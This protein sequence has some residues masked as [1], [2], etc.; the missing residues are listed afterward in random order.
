[1]KHAI[2]LALVAVSACVAL[3]PVTFTSAE[4]AAI[5]AS[6]GRLPASPPPDPS[7]RWAD[8]PAAADV[9]RDLFFDGR[10]SPA[11]VSCATCHD[12][13]T[14]FQD[15][16]AATSLGLDYTGRHAPTVIN[17]A[18][19][20][21]GAPWQFWDGRAD[22]QWAQALGP[23]E[24]P[25]E[26]GSARTAIALLLFDE[27][28]E[29]YEAVFGEMPDLRPGGV[30]IAA[31]TARPG[32]PEWDALDPAVQ[33]E[34]TGVYVNFGKAIA[35]Y[36]RGVVSADS[37][38]DAFVDA[39]AGGETDSD[40]LDDT[41]KLGLKV[42][43]GKGRCSVCH[44]GP[45][46]TDS[47]FYN[48][49]VAQTGEYVP[50]EDRGRESAIS[51]AFAAEFSCVSTWSD[52]ANPFACAV[53]QA[54]GD[55]AVLGAFKTPTLRGVSGTAP[56]MHTG[57]LATL[58]EVVDHYDG[59]GDPAGFVGTPALD[60]QRLFLTETEKQALVALMRAFDAGEAGP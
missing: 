5:R 32:T 24:S 40:L 8:D 44:R 58:E 45:N 14:G 23:P 38:V 18:Y 50:A 28:R 48:N 41:E 56:Y 30:A 25:V 17:A 33:A 49:A 31:E 43:V 60:V 9:G 6:F 22:S 19:T 26:M 15:A 47:R 13:A 12:P 11:G 51:G 10:Y 53:S 42:F 46:L 54:G 29:R 36:E 39:I 27:Y 7:N 2:L 55:E 57:A 3:E 52:A 21:A 35:A 16:R 4:L 1:M 59:G 34:I 37:R 20:N